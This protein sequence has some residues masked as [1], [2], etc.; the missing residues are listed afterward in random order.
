MRRNHQPFYVQWFQIGGFYAPTRLTL[1]GEALMALGRKE[2]GERRT[3]GQCGELIVKLAED[4]FILAVLGQFLCQ[5][6]LLQS[7]LLRKIIYELL[8]IKSL[9]AVKG[10]YDFA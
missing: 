3:A 1:A 9:A 7:S 6:I 10:Y 2:N 4:R 8:I 5:W